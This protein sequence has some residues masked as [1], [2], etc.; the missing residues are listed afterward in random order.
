MF[1]KRISERY[2]ELSVIRVLALPIQELTHPPMSAMNH[3]AFPPFHRGAQ[4]IS[5]SHSQ[6]CPYTSLFH[7]NL[8]ASAML[9]KVEIIFYVK[10]A[11]LSYEY[12]LQEMR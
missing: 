5:T 3:S 8:S 9:L 4:D 6:Q 11:V 7:D 12:L 1:H 10:Q 2:G